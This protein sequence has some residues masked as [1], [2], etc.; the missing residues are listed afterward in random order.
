MYVQWLYEGAI[1]S[2]FPDDE[3]LET[4]SGG[5]ETYLHSREIPRLIELYLLGSYLQDEAFRNAVMDA[6]VDWIETKDRFPI[7]EV[8]MVFEHTSKSSPLR[9]LF[10]DLHVLILRGPTPV[11]TAKVTNFPGIYEFW[12]A[13]GRELTRTRSG[14][15]PRESEVPWKFD[16]CRYHEHS[17]RKAKEWGRIPK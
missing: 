4:L 8:G 15:M 9:Q 5:H 17:D 1:F 3:T 11:R 7:R 6:L 12:G 13:I 2:S 14:A 16:N 10:I